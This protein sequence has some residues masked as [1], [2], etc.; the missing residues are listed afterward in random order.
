MI[1]RRIG[2]IFITAAFALSACVTPGSDVSQTPTPTVTE[3]LGVQQHGSPA[4][5]P[6]TVVADLK[7]LK[8][9]T[10]TGPASTTLPT[11]TMTGNVEAFTQ[12]ML[13]FLLT[14]GSKVNLDLNGLRYAVYDGDPTTLLVCSPDGRRDPADM[15]IA[16]RWCPAISALLVSAPTLRNPKRFTE[17]SPA[18]DLLYGYINGV[19]D[20]LAKDDYK[21]PSSCNIGLF[22][23]GYI[24]QDPAQFA[25]ASTRL[26][27][28]QRGGDGY[29]A[30]MLAFVRGDCRPVS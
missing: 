9:Q 13:R 6:S 14:V 17:Y 16:A 24:M 30:A 2:V 25:Y 1:L 7:A 8:I 23:R 21:D 20:T 27:E 22:Y 5:S 26:E 28:S 4:P 29:G 12:D 15:T 18:K 11:W 10:L 19:A 3:S